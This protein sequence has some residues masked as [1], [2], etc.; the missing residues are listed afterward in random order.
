MPAWSGCFRPR[1]WR[2]PGYRRPAPA[3]AEHALRVSRRHRASDP[4]R[5]CG[6]PVALQR[7]EVAKVGGTAR[8]GSRDPARHG[9]LVSL[10]LGMPEFE[11]EVKAACVLA[12]HWRI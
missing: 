7:E 10:L 9:G 1:R 2:I 8:E 12:I 3:H 11:S 4:D 6:D 5:Q